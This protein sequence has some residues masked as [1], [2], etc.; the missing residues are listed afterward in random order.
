MW[1][2]AHHQE[3]THAFL[4]FAS[5]KRDQQLKEIDAAFEETVDTR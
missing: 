1:W 2:T 4:R 3:Q 5:F